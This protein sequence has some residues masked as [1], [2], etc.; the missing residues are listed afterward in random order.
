MK[1]CTGRCPLL[2][3]FS[4]LILPA[5]PS[6]RGVKSVGP[7]PLIVGI[8]GSDPADAMDVCLLVSLRVV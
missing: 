7:W 4:N 2:R 3:I 8:V 1:Q 6:G 5:D